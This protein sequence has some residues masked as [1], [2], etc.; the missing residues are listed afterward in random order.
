MQAAFLSRLSFPGRCAF[1]RRAA[2]IAIVIALLCLLA[3][4]LFFVTNL[5]GDRKEQKQNSIQSIGNISALVEQEIERNVERYDASLLALA[6]KVVNPDLM[7]LDPEARQRLLFDHTQ[8]RDEGMEGMIVLDENGTV[9]LDSESLKP[10]QGHLADRDYF[11]IH[12]T[13]SADAGLYIGHPIQSRLKNG[14]WIVTLSRRFNHPDGSF[15]GVVV[16]AVQLDHFKRLFGKIILT[17]NDSITLLDADGAIIVRWPFS[18]GDAGKRLVDPLLL[19]KLDQAPGH[20]IET[21][22]IEGVQRL[23]DYRRIGHLPYYQRVSMSVPEVTDMWYTGFY[24][25]VSLIALCV[26]VLVLIR[27]LEFELRRRQTAEKALAEMATTD[28]LTGLANRRKFGEILASEWR[29]AER[30]NTPFSLLMFD[31]DFFKSYNDTYGHQAGDKALRAIADC[32]KACIK[33]PSDLAARYGGEEFAVLLPATDYAGALHIAEM[34]CA[35]VLAL[36]LRHEASAY[37]VMT[38]SAGVACMS[39]RQG[40]EPAALLRAAGDALY[41]AKAAGRNRAVSREPANLR[42]A[43]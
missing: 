23:H 1:Y 21:D 32:I 37:G 8:N 24:S 3:V 11:R 5:L 27:Q 33:R 40:Q 6:G 20:I 39:P 43:G 19:T 31:A 25:V 34:I 42:L 22:F 29:R 38:V 2:K 16:G 7:R 36:D 30:E 15:A 26:A 41:M 18:E 9:I 35:S 14:E 10:R 28:E 12:K 13:V 4:R 17:P